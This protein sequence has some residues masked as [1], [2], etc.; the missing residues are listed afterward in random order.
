MAEPPGKVIRG[1]KPVWLVAFSLLLAGCGG[2]E[3]HTVTL[4]AY[5][6]FPAQTI[7]GSPSPVECGK[8][9]RIFARDSL[10][11]LAHSS[12]N[13]AYPADLYYVI[14]REDFADF[15]G[16]RCDPALLGAA[17]RDRLTAKQRTALVDYLPTVIAD[18]V[19]KGLAP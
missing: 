2:G 18:V 19:R 8:D 17:L 3:R 7:S 11:F 4:P 10:A 14:L 5:G 9:A 12:T 6:N 1:V 15:Q 16:R 13:A